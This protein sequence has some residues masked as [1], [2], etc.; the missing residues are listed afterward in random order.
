MTWEMEHELL[1][2]GTFFKEKRDKRTFYTIVDCFRT[3]RLRRV[4]LCMMYIWFSCAIGYYGLFL[5][6]D[7]LVPNLALNVFINGALELIPCLISIFV[8]PRYGRKQPMIV[9]NFLGGFACILSCLVR[10]NTRPSA[11]GRTA[12]TLIGRLS[13]TGSA[14]SFFIWAAELYPTVMRGNGIGVCMFALRL[15]GVLAPQLLAL[16]PYTF[17][18]FPVTV[19]GIIALGGVVAAY[20]LPETINVNLPDTLPE[21]ENFGCKEAELRKSRDGLSLSSLTSVRMSHLSSQ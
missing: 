7:R 5:S 19:L 18:E 3:P 1:S 9:F 13:L 17:R 4:S 14:C 6:I 15:G 10:G 8:V 21:A 20:P 12:L 16:G 11:M 2:V